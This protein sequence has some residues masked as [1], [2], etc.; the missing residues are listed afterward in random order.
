VYRV[1]LNFRA[2]VLSGPFIFA[3]TEYPT[4]DH[5]VEKLT[6]SGST[7]GWISGT[8]RWRPMGDV[9][10][11][12]ASMGLV[13]K[14]LDQLAY[15]RNLSIMPFEMTDGEV[16]E[17]DDKSGEAI[18]K[19]RRDSIGLRVG[20]T[21]EPTVEST[22]ENVRRSLLEVPK[23]REVEIALYRAALANSDQVVRFLIMYQALLSIYND[24]Q[25]LVDEFVWE[26]D[27][28]VPKTTN[29]KNGKDESKFTRLRNEIGHAR[30]GVDLAITRREM[31]ASCTPL[32][33]LVKEAIRKASV[34]P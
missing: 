15:A 33:E 1:T 22:P 5:D 29:P 26:I 19:I 30:T 25:K 28:T 32:S 27:P 7:D 20:G 3:E 34:A 14:A 16:V 17:L 2:K 10:D 9:V 21:S 24:S 12:N 6:I 4:D 11:W 18:N 13:D 23:G 31:E 8:L